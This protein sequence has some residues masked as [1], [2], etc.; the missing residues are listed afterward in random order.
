MTRPANVLL[1]ADFSLTRSF[2]AHNLSLS[3][4][5]PIIM[6]SFEHYVGSHPSVLPCDTFAEVEHREG[7]L[8]PRWPFGYPA[9]YGL[10]TDLINKVLNNETLRLREYFMLPGYVFKWYY[11]YGEVPPPSSW[12]WQASAAQVYV[13]VA[14][15]TC[16]LLDCSYCSRVTREGTPSYQCV[17]F[18]SLFAQWFPDGDLWLD[19]VQKH[20]VK[21]VDILTSGDSSQ[22]MASF[23]GKK[24]YHLDPETSPPFT[25]FYHINVLGGGDAKFTKGIVRDQLSRIADSYA[26]DPIHN[27]TLTVFYNTVGDDSVITDTFMAEK[28]KKRGFTCVHIKHYNQGAEEVTL[29]ALSDFC[30]ENNDIDYRVMFMHSAKRETKSFVTKNRRDYVDSITS[31]ACL[32]PSNDD[33]DLCGSGFQPIPGG[34]MFGNYWAGKCSYLRKLTPS[35]TVHQTMQKLHDAYLEMERE[36]RLLT[37]LVEVGDYAYGTNGYGSYFWAGSHPSLRVC[38]VNTEAENRSSLLEPRWPLTSPNWPGQK[39]DLIGM[40]LG[41][42]SL[43]QREYFLLPG[44]IF[45]WFHL[46]GEAPPPDS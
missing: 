23:A 11:L 12:V 3:L 8:V 33:C 22:I 41:N 18:T 35:Y 32:R 44:Y 15:Y 26:N 43:R 36:E 25:I 24:L 27:R 40:V 39:R 17:A 29:Q 21:A 45:R 5:F 1:R 10:E 42:K 6:R 2:L 46:Y 20:A 38:D 31:K 14:W 9:W 7:L 37:N 4:L 28:C 19:A 16:A 13:A 34:Q 30:Q